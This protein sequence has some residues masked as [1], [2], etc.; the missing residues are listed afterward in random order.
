MLCENPDKPRVFENI[1]ASTLASSISG[2]LTNPLDLAKLRMQIQRADRASRGGN[3]AFTETIFGYR[4]MFHGIYSIA[5]KEGF[6]ALFRGSLMR[7]CFT[8]PNTTISL[9]LTEFLKQ[10]LLK[11][12]IF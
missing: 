9:V 5:K 10:Q 7:V 8:A 3:V 1:I 6:L 12:N 2:F 11:R 4:N